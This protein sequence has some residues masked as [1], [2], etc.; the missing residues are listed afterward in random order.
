MR[1]NPARALVNVTG[2]KV[3]VSARSVQA[4]ARIVTATIVK[5]VKAKENVIHA[6]VPENADG[7]KALEKR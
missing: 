4:L 7:V 2:V 6:T 5:N 1:A 3:T